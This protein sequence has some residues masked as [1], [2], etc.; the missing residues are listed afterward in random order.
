VESE[1]EAFFLRISGPGDYQYDG[2]DL[3]ILVTRGRL[4]T[5]DFQ[6][7][8]RARNW[9]DGIRAHFSTIDPAADPAALAPPRPLPAVGSFKIL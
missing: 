2:A 1:H 7:T 6:L 8:T 4:M 3:G 9:I 5:D